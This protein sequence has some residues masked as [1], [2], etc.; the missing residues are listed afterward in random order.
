VAAE[1]N[2]RLLLKLLV[3]AGYRPGDDSI[4]NADVQRLA[5]EAGIDN[6]VLS[7]ALDNVWSNGWIKNG[8]GDATIVL[9]PSG[10]DAGNA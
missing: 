9:T 2:A 3:K 5:A 8:P 4:Q 7:D 6:D 10:W 1:E